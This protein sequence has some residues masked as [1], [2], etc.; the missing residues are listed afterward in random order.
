MSL[1][2]PPKEPS[3]AEQ[4]QQR[5][6]QKKHQKPPRKPRAAPAADRFVLS[7]EEEIEAERDLNKYYYENL[8]QG[9]ALT[10]DE[11]A[12]YCRGLGLARS[13]KQLADMR[14]DYEFMAVRQPFRRPSDR[15]HV[16][17]LI[18]RLGVIMVS[19][20]AAAAAVGMF[21]LLKKPL[22]PLQV[23]IGEL[24]KKWRVSNGGKFY[25][26]VGVDALSQK[27]VVVPLARKDQKSW[28][29][30]ITQMIKEFPVISHFVSDADTA[31]S[32][33]A[34]Q[35]RIKAQYNI[36]WYHILTR[37]KSYKAEN[38]LA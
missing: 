9:I 12:N 14:L 5:Q 24:F 16:G 15:Q 38:K 4:Q 26:L 17:P 22:P 36:S 11:L 19:Q 25:L 34:F 6:P 18:D 31:V 35:A 8:R 33:A 37:S 13:R 3:A 2:S 30:G 32:G 7:A 1:G 10:V 23:D 21:L 27:L 28:E 29:A 20:P